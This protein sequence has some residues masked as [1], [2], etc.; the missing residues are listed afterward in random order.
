MSRWLGVN[1]RK[2]EASVAGSSTVD[3]RIAEYDVG[4]GAPLNFSHFFYCVCHNCRA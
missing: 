2:S 1:R 4:H 3:R